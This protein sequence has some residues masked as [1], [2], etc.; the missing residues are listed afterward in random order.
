MKIA[1][2]T[3]RDTLDNYI[4]ENINNSKVINYSDYFAKNTEKFNIVILSNILPGELSFTELL[5]ILKRLN[6]RVIFLC[7]PEYQLTSDDKVDIATYMSYGM[8]DILLTEKVNIDDIKN[9]ITTPRQLS[10]DFV[11]DLY[12]KYVTNE[13]LEESKSKLKSVLSKLKSFKIAKE[14]DTDIDTNINSDINANL[15]ENIKYIEKII[16]VEKEV[17]VPVEVPVFVEKIKTVYKEKEVIDNSVISLFSFSH[18]GKSFLSSILCNE[19]YKNDYSVNLISLDHSNPLEVYFNLN[20]IN[21]RYLNEN[22]IDDLFNIENELANGLLVIPSSEGN[23]TYTKDFLNE[24]ID[25][26]RNKYKIT[27]LDTDS[28]DIET[29]YSILSV[30]NTNLFIINTNKLDVLRNMNTLQGFYNNGLINLDKTII[31]I[32]NCDKGLSYNAT[33]KIIQEFENN[34]DDN[35]KDIIKINRLY[36][37]DDILFDSNISF[38][39]KKNQFSYDIDSL[40]ESLKIRIK[41]RKKKIFK[42]IKKYTLLYWKQILFSIITLI[43]IIII[44]KLLILKY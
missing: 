4:N 2:A 41:K 12:L 6:C 8:Y 40:L 39:I 32:N 30:S 23:I 21:A 43:L 10:N 19:F 17:E 31:V 16:E 11:K 29:L 28:K 25:T 14:S 3:G 34:V 35:F 18:T 38:G 37:L 36:E 5:F 20:E 22:S 44:Y 24:L 15:D 1:I 7:K 9:L 33:L 26:S 27:L 13:N 42:N